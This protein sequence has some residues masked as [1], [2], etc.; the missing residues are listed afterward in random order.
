MNEVGL[1][2]AFLGGTLSLLAPCSALLLP[3]FFAYAFQ[4]P[5]ELMLRTLIFMAGL[6]TLFIPLGMGV[7]FIADAV[8]FNR[9]AMIWTAGL[10]LITFG[11]MSLAGVSFGSPSGWLSRFNNGGLLS[12][13]GLG[14]VYGVAGVCSGPILGAV[15][16]IA[17][18]AETPWQSA[19][20]LT[21]YGVGMVVPLFSLALLWDR[22]RLGER[23]WLRGRSVS[24]GGR[25]IHSSQ[26]AAG[27]LFLVLGIVF[28]ATGGTVGLESFYHS[29][30]LFS[31]S[32][33]AQH[34]VRG[35]DALLVSYQW[36]LLGLAV[37]AG[38][39]LLARR[40]RRTSS[41]D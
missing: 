2:G 16:T 17:A 36:V 34:A 26:L 14:A 6:M 37:F 27:L 19:V 1:I 5:R 32:F 24:V 15:L 40:R 18:A 4:S 22:Y 39:L 31:L 33:Q 41:R 20:V 9:E 25:K 21:A 29:L 38:G 23:V 28:I 3:A 7:G 30:G 8:V 35:I 10:V 12:T 13:Y 11:L